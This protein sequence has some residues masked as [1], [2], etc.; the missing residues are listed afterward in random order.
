MPVTTMLLGACRSVAKAH[1]PISETDEEKALEGR[2]YRETE[3]RILGKC[4]WNQR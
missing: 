3:K 2:G 4:L 1:I